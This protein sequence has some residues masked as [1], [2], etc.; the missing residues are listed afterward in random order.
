MIFPQNKLAAR[1]EQR[2]LHQAQPGRARDANFPLYKC[3][4]STPLHI[5]LEWQKQT[6]ALSAME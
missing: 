6:A 4:D 3:H 2:V 5:E 1:V